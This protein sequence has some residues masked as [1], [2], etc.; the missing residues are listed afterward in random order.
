MMFGDVLNYFKKIESSNPEVI[1]VLVDDAKLRNSIIAWQQ[2]SRTEYITPVGEC[3][4]DLPD[5]QKW[6]WM[7]EKTKFNKSDFGV[8]AGLLGQEVD[9]ILIRLKG[10]RLIYPDGSVN[11]LAKQYIMSLVSNAIKKKKG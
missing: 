2:A 7:W 3:P 1:I 6:D 11:Q 10:L 4:S 8:A 5:N 9:N